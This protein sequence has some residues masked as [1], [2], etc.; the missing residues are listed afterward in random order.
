METSFSTK[1]RI[2]WGDLDAAG[3][4]FYPRLLEYLEK[5]IEQFFQ[6]IGH[7][8]SLRSKPYGYPVLFPRLELNIKF[9]RPISLGDEL[10]LQL[11][12]AKLGISS[13]KFD[14]KF[15]KG[16]QMAAQGSLVVAAVDPL[17]WK[18]IQIPEQLRRALEQ[19]LR[20]SPCS[21]E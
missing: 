11:Q 15:L 13:I 17:S 8:Y 6:S 19:F 4:I 7:G 14:F 3:I 16:D 5:G 21:P 9:L 20:S 2:Y 1:F 18:S 10:E 12:P